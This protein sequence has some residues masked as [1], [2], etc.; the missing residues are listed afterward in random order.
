MK[1]IILARKPLIGTVAKNVLTHGC[2]GLNI[3]A[4]RVGTEDR[5]Y[6]GSGV[7]EQRY[8]DG[9]AGLT[10]GRGR[11]T[12][13]EVT[14]RFPANLI[15]SHLEGCRIEG[16]RKVKCSNPTRAD[17]TIRAGDN[18]IYGKREGKDSPN[19]NYA[20]ERGLEETPNWIC[21]PGCPVAWLDNLSGERPS[22]G[23]THQ[24]KRS[25]FSYRSEQDGGTNVYREP[26]TGGASRFF[27]QI[28]GVE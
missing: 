25:G 21:E 26:D 5:S 7:S 18:E 23:V 12:V 1:T 6:K 24:P 17:G 27:K 13:Y 4:S 20:D 15:L 10:D 2:G 19:T 11:D 3:D 28:G 9:R 8:T 14:G 16:T 22:W